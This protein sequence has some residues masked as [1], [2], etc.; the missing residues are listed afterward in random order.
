MGMMVG[1]FGGVAL[2]FGAIG[3][4]TVRAIRAR[5]L[6]RALAAGGK[7]ANGKAAGGKAR[8]SDAAAAATAASNPMLL[9]RAGGGDDAASGAQPASPLARAPP[10]RMASAPMRAVAASAAPQSTARAPDV[11][12]A[13]DAASPAAFSPLRATARLPAGT[14][15]VAVAA[16]T[17]S[18]TPVHLLKPDVAQ[19]AADRRAASSRDL[20]A[21]GVPGGF[22]AAIKAA[23][24][25]GAQASRRRLSSAGAGS[26]GDGDAA[27]AS[28]AAS[29]HADADDASDGLAPGWAAVWSK[30][31]STWYWRHADGQ[32]TTWVKPLA[33]S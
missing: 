23:G 1:F 11:L 13:D 4:L 16:L 15:S 20:L 14:T 7:A 2:L 18:P 28:A 9:S 3:I 6:R 29:G 8:G 22:N 10:V 24:A 31:R 27:A 26:D 33:S 30:S 21:L 5:K 12:A 32:Q 25:G 19:V 17:L